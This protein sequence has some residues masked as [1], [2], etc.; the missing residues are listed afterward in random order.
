MSRQ[1]H[2]SFARDSLRDHNNIRGIYRLIIQL[3]YCWYSLLLLVIV[4]IE[5][6]LL[7]QSISTFPGCFGSTDL[8]SEYYHSYIA[9][10]PLSGGIPT[11]SKP[12]VPL[13]YGVNLSRRIQPG[14]TSSLEQSP[15]SVS[16]P[17]T[18]VG[19]E[20]RHLHPLIYPHLSTTTSQHPSL[21]LFTCEITLVLPL[22][23]CDG[24]NIHAS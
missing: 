1:Y 15:S 17:T 4:A 19:Q 13:N 10:V 14:I 16:G 23:R 20:P 21:A 5:I 8:L 22:I 11:Y 24:N 3:V 12:V 7:K 2:L 9:L 18:V 6:M